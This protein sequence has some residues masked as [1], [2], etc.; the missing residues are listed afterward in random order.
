MTMFRKPYPTQGYSSFVSTLFLRF[1]I[2]NST[3]TLTP[4]P[5]YPVL[6][7][8]W[9]NSLILSRIL[10]RLDTRETGPRDRSVLRDPEWKHS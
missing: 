8:R 2:E 9:Y 10:P 6:T 3:P 5:V 4:L 7:G 1:T